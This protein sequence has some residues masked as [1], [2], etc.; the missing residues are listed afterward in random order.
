[1][2]QIIKRKRTSCR[3]GGKSPL[4]VIIPV[5]LICCS[6]AICF[7][8]LLFVRRHSNE[9]AAIIT[10]NPPSLHDKQ[11]SGRLQKNITRH[12][13]IR[14]LSFHD[15][16]IAARYKYLSSKYNQSQSIDCGRG[17]AYDK[18]F[19]LDS[20]NRS[21]FNEDRKLYERF[22][23]KHRHDENFKNTYVEL[24]AF[25]G[26]RESNT[27]FFDECLGWDGLLIEGNPTMYE[28]LVKN[29][30]NS[31][32][33][34]YAP[35][36]VHAGETVEFYAAS[37]T[38]AGLTDHVTVIKNNKKIQVPCGPLGPILE[39]MFPEGHI[40]FF[41]LDVEGAEKLVLDTIDFNKIRVD[42]FM[43]EV[44]NGLCKRD[45]ECEVRNQVRELM[46]TAGYKTKIK[47]CP[48]VGC[49]CTSR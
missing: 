16:D 9:L 49:I 34:S 19:S 4:I 41:S 38:N 30:P 22:F 13:H 37:F 26:V 29:R 36:C 21:R 48:N 47:R 43:I 12:E 31:H 33:L 17:P 7:L 3:R 42:V 6:L 46:K 5:L 2:V 25:D 1:M 39:K 24:G 14:S 40:T 32:R 27:R 11:I 10:D 45:E 28:R 23:A 20:L 8:S 44:E 15:V 18:Y 35:S